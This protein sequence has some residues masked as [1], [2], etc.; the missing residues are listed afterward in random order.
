MGGY[1]LFFGG[2]E[3]HGSSQEWSTLICTCQ[4]YPRYEVLETSD[5]VLWGLEVLAPGTEPDTWVSHQSAEWV[6][7]FQSCITPI[8]SS[9]WSSARHT[10]GM[11]HV[12]VEFSTNGLLA[13]IGI[14][15]CPCVFTPNPWDIFIFYIVVFFLTRTLDGSSETLL[16]F[17]ITGAYSFGKSFATKEAGIRRWKWC[18]RVAELEV[19]GETEG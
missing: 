17:G 5:C 18:G 14:L 16:T 2:K 10:V 3:E 15:G 8:D 19:W 13:I 11:Q 12:C 4:I 9:T 6:Q 1:L 7:R